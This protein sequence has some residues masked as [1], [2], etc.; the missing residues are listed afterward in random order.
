MLIFELMNL[1]GMHKIKWLKKAAM[2]RKFLFIV[3]LFGLSSCFEIIQEID[4]NEDG[5]VHLE[6]V[7]NFSRSQ[8]KIDA[9]LLLDQVNGHSIPTLKETEEKFNTFVDSARSSKGITQ[10]KSHFDQD[11]YIFEFSCDFD[12]IERINQRVYQ[13]AKMKDSTAVLNQLFTYKNQVF[14]QSLGKPMIKAFNKMSMADREVLVGADYTSIFRFKKEVI[15]NSNQ[16]AMLTPHKK[17]VILHSS[18]MELIHHPER[19]NHTIKVKK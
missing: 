7:L 15:S 4:L 3:M 11:Q 5:S 6:V 18:V 16:A 8:T 17:V 19:V 13:I 12:K 10:V 1:K 14:K 2:D 9:L